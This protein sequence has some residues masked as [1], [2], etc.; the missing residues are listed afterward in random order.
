MLH[1][2]FQRLILSAAGE[3]VG[4]QT[5]ETA[6]DSIPAPTRRELDV[7]EHSLLD[8][9]KAERTRA[10]LEPLKM[11]PELQRLARG[12]AAQVRDEPLWLVDD[13]GRLEIGGPAIGAAGKDRWYAEILA[14]VR[15]LDEVA[16]ARLHRALMSLSTHRQFILEPLFNRAGIGAVTD[17]K[18]SITL[19]ALFSE[20]R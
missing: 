1:T 9:V 8:L 18:G 16:A 17:E 4:R 2:K 14:R 10:G 7:F 6:A 5:S 15:G 12:R 20:A 11:Y 3:H 19:V 13:L